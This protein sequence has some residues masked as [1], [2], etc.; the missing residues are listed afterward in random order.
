[1][2]VQSA[3]AARQRGFTLVEI[4]VVVAIISILMMVA[5]PFYQSYSVQAKVGGEI[6]SMAP[7]KHLVTE[8]YLI[9]DSWPVSNTE[10]GATEPESYGGTYLKSVA[11]TNTPIPGS[12][13]LL[14]DDTVLLALNGANTIIY[15]PVYNAD[16]LVIGWACDEGTMTNRYRPG[17]CKN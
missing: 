6:G 5:T 17:Q 8:H 12:I 3:R 4:L 7:V 13:E 16:G 1:M 9:N 11:V 2:N 10:A 15:Y 14:Y